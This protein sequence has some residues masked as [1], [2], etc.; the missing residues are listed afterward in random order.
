MPLAIPKNSKLIVQIG[1]IINPVSQNLPQ[2]TFTLTSYTG[3][4]WLYKI[5]RVNASLIPTF[6]CAFP[7]ATCP[8]HQQKDT[9]LSCF[10]NNPLIT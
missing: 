3:T 4:N 2:L 6:K 9:C 8:S 1:P 10:K 5:D 7:C